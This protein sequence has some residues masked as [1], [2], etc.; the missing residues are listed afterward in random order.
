[1]FMIQMLNS[2]NEWELCH[3][4]FDSREAAD[5]FVTENLYMFDDYR[6]TEVKKY[7]KEVDTA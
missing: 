1:M 4:V 7:Q 2:N 5:T 6:I 3:W